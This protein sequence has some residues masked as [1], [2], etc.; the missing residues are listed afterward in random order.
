MRQARC[1]LPPLY[2]KLDEGISCYWK[3]DDPVT[4]E[5]HTQDRDLKHFKEKQL[6]GIDLRGAHP[7]RDF[8]GLA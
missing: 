3:I 5:S 4:R 7:R 6:D 8:I 1:D 2:D